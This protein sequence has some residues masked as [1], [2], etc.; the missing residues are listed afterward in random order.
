MA[1]P[2]TSLLSSLQLLLKAWPASA[3]HALRSMYQLQQTATH[4]SEMGVRE[5]AALSSSMT[6]LEAAV[7]CML[8][9]SL[10]P[11]HIEAR[12][13]APGVASTCSRRG[14]LA[15]VTG[16]TGSRVFSTDAS[17][18]SRGKE[19]GDEQRVHDS[20]V[21]VRRR[22]SNSHNSGRLSEAGNVTPA[23]RNQNWNRKNEGVEGLQQLS[24]TIAGLKT[25]REAEELLVEQR[26]QFRRVCL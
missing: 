12:R 21:H 10:H 6:P 19:G 13:G 9:S 20:A 22:S 16:M 5:P 8:P 4:M 18:S 24:R 7:A 2:S 11:C 23:L 14:H 15:D 1:T 26:H 25:L 3:G 17:A